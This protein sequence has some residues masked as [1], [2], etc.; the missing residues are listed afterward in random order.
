M[1]QLAAA[2]VGDTTTAAVPVPGVGA[3]VADGAATKRLVAKPV[4]A[5]PKARSVHAFT[6]DPFS[7]AQMLIALPAWPVH[8]Q[9]FSDFT[10]DVRKTELCRLKPPPPVTPD[11]HPAPIKLR[12]QRSNFHQVAAALTALL[13]GLPWS[14]EPHPGFSDPDIWRRRQRPATDGWPEEEEKEVQR[15]RNQQR[16]LTITVVTHPFWAA[17]EGP[18]LVTARMQLT[19][20]TPPHPPRTGGR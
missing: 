12:W 14:V 18:D 1:L 8:Q 9:G 17:F 3:A 13:E 10:P 6:F 7:R 2:A 19:P 4:V 11:Q 20:T 16:E 15:L 5:A